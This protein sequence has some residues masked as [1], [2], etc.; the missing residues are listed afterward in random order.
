[1]AK[2]EVTHELD[3]LV[4][5]ARRAEPPTLSRMSARRMVKSALDR[6]D[7]RVAIAR[8]RFRYVWLAAAAALV[9]SAGSYLQ[10]ARPSGTEVATAADGLPL[11]L[12]LKTGDTLVLAPATKIE[13]LAEQ[14]LLRRVRVTRGDT[15]FDVARSPKKQQFEVSTP[16]AE[17]RVRGTVFTVR[18]DDARTVVRVH[19]GSVWV[20]RQVLTAGAV[21]TSDGKALTRSDE[22]ERISAS[23]VRAAVAAHSPSEAAAQQPASQAL[24]PVKI[25]PQAAI[26]AL[27]EEQLAPA[28]DAPPTASAPKPAP[29]SPRSST[30]PASSDVVRGS[31]RS[32]AGAGPPEQLDVHQLRELLR[33]GAAEHVV[34]YARAHEEDD[35]FALILADGL[36]ALGRFDEACTSYEALAL[37]APEPLRT[38]AG[39][40]AA[41]LALSSQRDAARALRDIERFALD[42]PDSPLSERASML[43]VEVLLQLG[44]VAEAWRIGAHY[45][46]RQPET[47]AKERM[48]RLLLGTGA[49]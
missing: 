29:A 30:P 23:D 14:P 7:Q 31:A 33:T 24:A 20:E 19:E 43:H 38:Q 32:D 10:L 16:H 41:R 42:R 18:V 6:R 39:F 5:Q 28:P 45:L 25:P 13:V 48:R 40:A 17:I 46:S 44:R 35:A 2:H 12:S 3:E 8:R 22:L 15:L 9:L 26:D 37:R 4:A 36:R 34:R 1:M 27:L 21:W 11:R 49:P 47:E